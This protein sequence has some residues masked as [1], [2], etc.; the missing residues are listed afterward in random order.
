MRNIICYDDSGNEISTNILHMLKLYRCLRK[1]EKTQPRQ[2][3][4][5]DPAVGTLARPDQ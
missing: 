5:Y 4:Y 1:T 3:V 2:F